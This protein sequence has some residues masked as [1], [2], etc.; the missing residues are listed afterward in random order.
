[1]EINNNQN[2]RILHSDTS[3]IKCNLKGFCLNKA[4]N[5]D[6]F[7]SVMDRRCALIRQVAEKV[8]VYKKTRIQRMYVEI[9]SVLYD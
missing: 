7:Y 3:G 4:L 5:Q 6:L 2:F 8:R 1:M 9:V